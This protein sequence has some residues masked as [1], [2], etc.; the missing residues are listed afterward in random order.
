MAKLMMILTS[1]EVHASIPYS[2]ICMTRYGAHWDTM[3][4]KRRW[5][6]EFTEA[7]GNRPRSSSVGPM[8][9]CLAGESL[10]KSG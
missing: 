7:K 1:Q 5:K 6:M 3:R 10:T 8:T 2:L 4:R 9:G